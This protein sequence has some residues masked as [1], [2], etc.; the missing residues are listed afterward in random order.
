MSDTDLHNS[1]NVVELPEQAGPEPVRTVTDFVRD[2]PLLVVAGGIAIGAIAASLLPRGAG[3][4]IAKHAISLAELAGT[5]GALLGT[6]VRETAESAGSTLRESGD[7]VTE[8]LGRLGE[9]ASDRL[10]QL[11]EAASARAGKLID[12]VEGAAALVAKKAG[13]LRSRIRH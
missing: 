13:E 1:D 4:R 9:G 7:A 11:G 12:P 6:R 8:R 10:G 3:R 2:H 5:A